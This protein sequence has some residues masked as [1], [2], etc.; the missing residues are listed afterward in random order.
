MNLNNKTILITGASSGI[1]EACAKLFAKDGCRLILMAR[2]KEKLDELAAFL[3]KTHNTHSLILTVDI[4]DSA[5]I[6]STIEKLPSEWQT[7]DIL[8]NNAG[9]A[10]ASDPIQNGL[11]SNWETMIDTNVKGL[12]YVTRAIL[13]GM[14]AREKGHIIN[15]SSVAGQECYPTGN[16]YCATKHAV[17]A[18]SKSMRLD[19]LGTK[20]KVSDIAPGAVETEFSEVRWQDKEKAKK[21]YSDFTPLKGEDIADT[22]YYCL[23][24]P[25]HVNIAEMLVFPAA[26]AA[27]SQIARKI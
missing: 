19:L 1:G 21:F 20:I 6:Q 24:R 8:I 12:L 22:V 16:V 14:I 13:P 7:I 11:I 18:L 3:K 17:K 23:T 2:R 4:Q 27:A 25:E 9:L 26:Q 15:I 5:A 10:L